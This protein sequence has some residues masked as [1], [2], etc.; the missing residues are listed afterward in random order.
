MISFVIQLPK[1]RRRAV[2][3][4][5]HD[6]PFKPKVEKNKMIYKRQPKHQKVPE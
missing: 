1:Q 3:L 2:E 5:A 6:T 4:Y